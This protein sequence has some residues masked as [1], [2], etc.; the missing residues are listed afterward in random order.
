[1]IH[2]NLK[3]G[4][5]ILE[6]AMEDYVFGRPISRWHP[7]D[8]SRLSFIIARDG[9]LQYKC[10]YDITKDDNKVMPLNVATEAIDYFV[11]NQRE[12]FS[13]GHIILEFICEEPLSRLDL[14]EEIVD[15]FK[16]RIYL[17]HSP[18]FG[19]YRISIVTNGMLYS[20]EQMQRFVMMNSRSLL[21]EICIGSI[22]HIHDLQIANPNNQE[23]LTDSERNALHCIKQY[24]EA[25]TKITIGR[26][27]LSYLME[28]IIYLWD[29]GLLYVSV[30]IV[31]DEIREEDC[32]IFESQLMGIADYILDNKLWDRYNTTLFDEAVGLRQ[33]NE[34]G[35]TISDIK[36]DDYVIDAEGKVY[37]NIKYVGNTSESK[38]SIDYGNIYKG[39]RREQIR[40]L[41]M[42]SE[43]MQM[44][45]ANTVSE[46]GIYKSKVKVNNY[47]W[48]KLYNKYGIDRRKARYKLYMDFEKHMYF[49]L[50][51]NCVKLCANYNFKENNISMTKEIILKGLE[52]AKEEFCQPVFLYSSCKNIENIFKAFDICN[53]LECHVIKHIIPFDKKLIRKITKY[54]KT[55]DLTV[56]IDGSNIKDVEKTGINNCILIVRE[57]EMLNLFDWV[58]KLFPVF[59]RIDLKCEVVNFDSL[60]LYGEQITRIGDRLAEERKLNKTCKINILNGALKLNEMENCFAGEK[61]VTIAPDGKRYICPAFYFEKE[62]MVNV[63][64]TDNSEESKMLKLKSAPVCKTCD[65]YQCE[66]CVYINKKYTS[67]YNM[68]SQIQ[69]MKSNKEH[70]ILLKL[71]REL[72]KPM[73]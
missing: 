39:V 41:M 16:V 24:P 23:S 69:C 70:E 10:S 37:P 13:S 47:Y 4:G 11:K 34:D 35:S 18:W 2:K 36:D 66:R 20:S 12:L 8:I 62:S 60:A 29:L 65:V 6:V 44:H 43:K 14:I 26:E 49:M 72:E 73:W 21:M 63:Y 30:D 52:T 5:H 15:Y 54:V 53:E 56:V 40:S 48:A 71:K 19:R 51:S 59:S 27:D 3:R 22:K 42:F 7:F 67:E 17:K 31:L 25:V 28:S 45:S 58:E 64:E 55:N 38:E 1:M 9:S 32:K 61:D 57:E 50:D 33:I 46:D 68:P